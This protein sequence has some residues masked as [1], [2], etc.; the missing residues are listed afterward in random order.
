MNV[1]LLYGVLNQKDNMMSEKKN[2]IYIAGNVNS[3]STLLDRILNSHIK[4]MGLGEL[5]NFVNIYLKNNRNCAC[6]KSIDNCQFWSSVISEIKKIN[7]IKCMG[8]TQKKMESV[9]GIFYYL[10]KNKNKIKLYSTYCNIVFANGIF[11]NLPKNMKYI[12]DSSKSSIKRF[13]RPFM[14]AKIGGFN[15]YVI[16]LIRDGRACIHSKIKRKKRLLMTSLSSSIKWLLANISAHLSKF[17]LPRGNYIRI[18]YEDYI[19]HPNRIFNKIGSFLDIDFSEINEILNITKNIPLSHQID[20]NFIR[21]VEDLK[22]NKMIAFKWKK[23]LKHKYKI[24]FW[25]INWPFLLLYKY[26]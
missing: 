8:N 6:G 17:Y 13:W 21:K 2:I 12:V 16:H 15:V 4:I 11:K 1:Q 26:R 23:E 7:H 22:L 24:F 10:F 14:L 25:F 18:K 20:G 5:V 3:G 9:T 19:L